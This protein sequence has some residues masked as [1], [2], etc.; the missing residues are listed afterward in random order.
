[1]EQSAYN[2]HTYTIIY[3]LI[4][5]SDRFF[6]QNN[7]TDITHCRQMIVSMYPVIL[8]SNNQNKKYIILVFYLMNHFLHNC[9]RR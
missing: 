4:T 3:I 7:C 5:H 1:M 8:Y 6:H 2:I 9:S